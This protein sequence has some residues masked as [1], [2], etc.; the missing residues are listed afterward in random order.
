MSLRI[1]HIVFVVVSIL[2][3]VFAGIWGVR[4][5]AATHDGGSL[6]VGVLFL[7]CGAVLVPYG[8]RV[9]QKLKE[10]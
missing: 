8:L 1:F 5:Y 2:L 3:C 10:L 6:F 9:Y 4:Q 7:A